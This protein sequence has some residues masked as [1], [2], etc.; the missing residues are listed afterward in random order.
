MLTAEARPDARP[1]ALGLL[2]LG[3][4]LGT[5]TGEITTFIAVVVA[6]AL[7][8]RA[9]RWTGG[10]L[11]G[12]LAVACAAWLAFALAP[13]AVPLASLGRVWALTAIFAA[14]SLAAGTS[15]PDG[16]SAAAI[17]AA[18]WCLA[19]W[20]RAV[21]TGSTDEDAVTGPWDQ[22]LTT[23]YTLL[24]FALAAA[25][26][27][28]WWAILLGAAVASTGST[29]ATAG[30]VG[31]LAV[32]LVPERAKVAV[33]AAVPAATVVA[34]ALAPAV[35]HDRA[36]LWTGGLILAGRGG[37]PPGTWRTA[38]TPVHHALSP[39]F[40]FPQH[41][42][43]AAVQIAGDAGPAG[44]IAL[45]WGAVVVVRRAPRWGLAIAAAVAAGG[46]SQDWIGDLDAVRSI[47][48]WLALALAEPAVAAAFPR[49]AA[50]APPF[51]SS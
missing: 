39:G 10:P 24:P 18:I 23:A 2:L 14:G 6:L 12:P 29:G 46:L 16:L 9:R 8:V 30:L 5:T 1:L 21:A 25:G 22:H 36:I 3:L 11:D 45:A 15:P 51:S 47:G 42:H 4:S 19:Q 38:I 20:I 49:D 32:L 31:G 35:V 44:W 7:A 13:N 34:M 17:P 40:E 28:R 48:V 50:E 41:S 33:A 27:R 43:D 26:K 37:V